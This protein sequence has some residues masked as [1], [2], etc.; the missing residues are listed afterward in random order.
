LIL[1][2][3]GSGKTR[4]I[5]FRVA[6][7]VAEMRVRPAEIMAVTF[8]NKAAG[9][10]VRRVEALLGG[11][12]RTHGM[13]VST[14]HSSCARIL[15]R[16][17]DR[18]GLN[19]DYVIYDDSDQRAL[20][21]RIVRDLGLAERM[22]APRDVLSRI[23]SAK[24]AGIGPDRYRAS[25]FLSDAVAKIYPI[26]QR[27]LRESNACDFGDLLLHV[28]RLLDED[29]GVRKELAGRFRHVLVDEFQDTNQVQYRLV[30]RLASVHGNLCVVGDDD[31][32]IYGWRG[33]DVENILDFQRDYP[34]ARVIKLERNYR[35]TQVILDAANA[36]IARN[37]TR[38]G[39]TLYTE[40]KGG[41]SILLYEAESERDEARFV[42]LAIRK[43]MHEE[44]KTGSDFAVFYRT[45]AQSRVIEE[46]LRAERLPYV[47]VG[48][49]RFY[50]R[51]E[52]K[53]VVAYLRLV[54]NPL[55][56]ASLLRIVN[57]P[58]RGI[59]DTTIDR[60]V[61][62]ARR[63]GI[64]L[65]DALRIA[66]RE[67]DLVGTAAR[68]KIGTFI[69]LLDSL[70]EEAAH[71]S[72]ASLVERVL[73]RTGYLERLSVEGSTEAEAR[74]GNL[75]E[76]LGDVRE[77]ESAARQPTVGEYLERIT[78]VS[79]ADTEVP[80]GKI[81]LMTVHAAKGL[82]F[83]VAFL[84]GL[85]ETIFPMLRGGDSP[86]DLE[87]ERRLAY[88]AITRARERLFLSYAR[89]RRL[90][91]NELLNQPSR[92][93][94]DIP[95]DLIVVPVAPVRRP[96][97]DVPPPRSFV[98]YDA[99]PEYEFDQSAPGEDELPYRVGQRVRHATFGEGEVRGWTGYGANLKLT[100]YFRSAGLKTIVA[101]FV[102]PV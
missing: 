9:E 52:I 89:A 28:L 25:D 40:Q 1:A 3:A 22:F 55:D 12:A 76:F 68:R 66:A 30:R 57:V 83:P 102:E 11:G 18:V 79:D 90:F 23:D 42:T 59:G 27:R 84:T 7:L 34:S 35:S 88:V 71:L 21:T 17:G 16:F 48:G 91:G 49:V 56:E 39:K 45:N 33:A 85:E 100:V 101:R 96:V 64:P 41:E 51:A 36:V 75:M 73:E 62:H 44:Q 67:D 78:L 46:S 82:E 53:D 74:A 58:T 31:Q 43:L 29:E 26:Y 15:R 99:I 69:E 65:V 60:V 63:L 24:N 5:T 14:F 98:D 93:L 97:H 4:V 95:E 38:L 61:G 54:T 70:R 50:D 92:F 13:W 81:S 72:P 77:Y 86:T 19:R 37:E 47:V 32:S 87:E 8:T 10:L 94:S 2:G 6:H 80:G 20:V